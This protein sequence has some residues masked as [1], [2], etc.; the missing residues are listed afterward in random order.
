MELSLEPEEATLLQ[1]ILTNYL[2]DL[3]SEISHT[4]RYDLRQALKHDE[5]VL[6]RLLA[7]LSQRDA[8]P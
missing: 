3:R 6:K 4:D 1:Q 7:R 8:S 5:A 2:S